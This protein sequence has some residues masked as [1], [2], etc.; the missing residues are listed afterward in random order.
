MTWIVLTVVLLIVAGLGVFVAVSASKGEAKGVGGL[1]AVVALLI[2]GVFTGVCAYTT[3][4]TGSV[5]ATSFAGKPDLDTYLPEGLNWVAPWKSVTYSEAYKRHYIDVGSP[6]AM[7]VCVTKDEMQVELDLTYG[8]SINPQY[9]PRLL[10]HFKPEQLDSMATSAARAATQNVVNRKTARECYTAKELLVKEMEKEFEARLAAQ[11]HGLDAFANFNQEQL[12]SVFSVLPVQAENILPPARVKTAMSENQAASIEL[13]RQK[14]LKLVAE[15][16]AARQEQE[17]VG[18][19]NLI[20][21]LPPGTT[22]ADAALII[23]AAAEIK[24]AKALEQAVADSKVS[25]IYI[26]DPTGDAVS[27]PAAPKK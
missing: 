1:V 6:Q 11:L 21:Q 7:E 8:F 25:V 12:V 2:W 26:S 4:P 27:V 23:R 18:L 20:A 24:R 17:G 15:A 5:G 13:E 16:A 9:A 14:T 3:V 19:K 22:P 10:R